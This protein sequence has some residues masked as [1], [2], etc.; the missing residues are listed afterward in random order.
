[1]DIQ[2][3]YILTK[4]T[5]SQSVISSLAVQPPTG[6]CMNPEI[7][8]SNFFYALELMQFNT[9]PREVNSGLYTD[10]R[11]KMQSTAWTTNEYAVQ[12]QSYVLNLLITSPSYSYYVPNAALKQGV[13]LNAWTR[14]NF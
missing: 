10:P 13:I 7:Q 2:L 11:Y 8:T 1:M 5:R 14:P 4:Q 12:S 9:C 3:S 6:V